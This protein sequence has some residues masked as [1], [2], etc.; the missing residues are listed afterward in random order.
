MNQETLTGIVLS[1]M[2]MGEYD[3]RLVILTKECG[4]ISAFAKGARKPNCAL[5]ACSQPFSFGEFTLYQGRSSYTI[6]SANITNYFEELRE[7][8][9]TVYYGLYFCEF[10]DYVTRENINS[11]DILKLLYQSLRALAKK[12]IPI[13]LIRYIFELKIMEFNGEAPQVFECIKC[14]NKKTE[15]L[16]S[17]SRGGLVCQSCKGQLEDG[18]K[19]SDSS[20]YTMQFIIATPVEKLYT[21]TVSSEVLMELEY[22]MKKYLDIY[23]NHKFN[24]LGMVDSVF[25]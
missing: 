3:K 18:I 23:V 9:E 5:L 25:S 16:F 6:T 13:K 8:L 21:F 2:P 4:K 7:D 20:I 12:T 15:Y 17:C 19:L 22:L 1:A 24:S 10:T 11:T 14:K